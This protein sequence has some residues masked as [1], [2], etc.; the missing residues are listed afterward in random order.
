V[1]FLPLLALPL[2][3]CGGP[4]ETTANEAFPAAPPTAIQQRVLDLPEGQRRGVLLRAILDS[5][6][7]CQGVTAAP[8][9]PD[10]QPPSWNAHCGNGTNWVVAIGPDG[11]ARVT[12]PVAPPRG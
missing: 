3:A 7:Q 1:R 4:S 11:T 10:R 9:I 6:Q 5:G 8:R 2:A 12:G